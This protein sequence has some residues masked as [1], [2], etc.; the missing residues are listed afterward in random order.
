M[1]P[2][3]ALFCCAMYACSDFRTAWAGGLLMMA[4]MCVPEEKKS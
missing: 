4:A 2:R 3:I 1:I